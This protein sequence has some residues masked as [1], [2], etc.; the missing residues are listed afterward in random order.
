MSYRL[1]G[2]QT[3]YESEAVINS[4]FITGERLTCPCGW[5]CEVSHMTHDAHLLASPALR[6]HH[7]NCPQARIPNLSRE[8]EE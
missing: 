1:D 3:A 4:E 8:D 5:T 7:D 2:I 6:F